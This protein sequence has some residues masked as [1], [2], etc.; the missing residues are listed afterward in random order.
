MKIFGMTVLELFLDQLVKTVSNLTVNVV[1]GTNVFLYRTQDNKKT[2]STPI[3][4]IS[5]NNTVGDF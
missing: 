4:E 5:V 1:L 2:R 3:D